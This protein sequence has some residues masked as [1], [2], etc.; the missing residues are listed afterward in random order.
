MTS[1]VDI[2]VLELLCSRLCHELISP[3]SA[4]SNGVELMSDDPGDM[5][6]EIIG[7]LAMSSSQASQRLKFYRI[8]YGLGGEAASSMGLTDAGTL[9]RGIVEEEKI[10]LTW[11][12]GT[13]ALGRAAVRVLLNASLMAVEALPRGGQISVAISRSGGTA[14]ELTVTASGEG[15]QLWEESIAALDPATGAD[16]LT[17]R[18]V[19]AYFTRLLAEA[20]GGSFRHDSGQDGR[21]ILTA[22]LP[23]TPDP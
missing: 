8:A 17:P 14:Q 15:A 20:A 3:V 13:E 5:L 9:V 6:G 19:Q 22:Q 4:I 18:S 1:T 2:R 23:D 21:V 16:A 11:P 12:G 7:L 10:N